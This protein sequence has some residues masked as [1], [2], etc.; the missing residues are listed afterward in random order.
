MTIENDNPLL[1]PNDA[2]TICFIL[3]FSLESYT[4]EI[5]YISDS[6]NYINQI[7]I[8][9]IQRKKSQIS[10]FH[11][12]ENYSHLSGRLLFFRIL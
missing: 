7:E 4:I 3:F 5:F 9:K 8:N 12:M 1:F 2:F 10:N 11:V 6:E